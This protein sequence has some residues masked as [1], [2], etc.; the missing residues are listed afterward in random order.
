[1]VGYFRCF[2]SLCAAVL[3]ACMPKIATSQHD[4]QS[5]P[6]RLDVM[7]G[8]SNEYV[9]TVVSF[10]AL[11]EL[12]RIGFHDHAKI[13]SILSMTKKLISTANTL[14]DDRRTLKEG[15]EMIEEANAMYKEVKD[16]IAKRKLEEEKGMLRKNSDHNIHQVEEDEERAFYVAHS[17]CQVVSHFA[18]SGLLTFVSF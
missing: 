3:A 1:M 18:L 7:I 13:T 4:D 15:T 16:H 12:L 2:F 5:A 11:K 14:I 9:E 17:V 6:C 8:N 10:L